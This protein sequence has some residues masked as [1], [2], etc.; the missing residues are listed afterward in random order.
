[1]QEVQHSMEA[2]SALLSGDD[3]SGALDIVDCAQKLLKDGDFQQLHCMTGLSQKLDDYAGLV[4]DL[5]SSRFVTFALEGVGKYMDA[6][7]L[8]KSESMKEGDG[9]QQEEQQQLKDGPI[10]ESQRDDFLKVSVMLDCV[11]S[12]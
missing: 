5:L 6:S 8:V 4:G 10:Q 2:I 1:M 9:W 3:L 11:F 12:I 7:K